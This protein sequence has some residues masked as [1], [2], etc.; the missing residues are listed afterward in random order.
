[1]E[2]RSGQSQ[3]IGSHLTDVPPVHV[4]GEHPLGSAGGDANSVRSYGINV[5]NM[6]LQMGASKRHDIPPREVRFKNMII[7]LAF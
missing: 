3:L 5:L 7:E 2:L 1:M 6:A 4:V